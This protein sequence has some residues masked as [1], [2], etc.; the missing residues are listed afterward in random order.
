MHLSF[1]VWQFVRLMVRLEETRGGATAREALYK[2]WRADWTTLDKELERLSETDFAAFAQTMMDQEVVFEE[3]TPEQRDTVVAVL[4]EVAN[5]IQ[6]EASKAKGE[7]REDLRFEAE[8]LA[9]LAKDM[10]AK[11]N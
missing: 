4:R 6:T 11:R 8:Q 3:A 1:A 9:A 2:A 10:A 5:R 7:K